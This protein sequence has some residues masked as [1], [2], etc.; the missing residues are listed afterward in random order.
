MKGSSMSISIRGI[1]VTLALAA[2]TLLA[3]NTGEITGT[4]ADASGAVIVGAAVTITNTATSQTREV[5]TNQAGNYSVP[6]LVPGTYDL[7]VETSGFKSVSRRGVEIQVGAVARIDFAMEVGEVSQRVEVSGGAPLL[8]TENAAVGTVI[9]NKRIV[10]LPL[11]GRNYLQLVALSP[12]VTT[13]GGAGGGG[14]LQG[15]QRSQSSFSIAGQRLEYNRYT[16]DGVENTDPN[17]NS[18]IIQPSVDFIQEFKVQTGVYSA[19]F[20][21]AVSQ[22]S[23]STKGGAN[24]YHGTAFEFLRN[25]AMD[26]KQWNT[27]VAKNPFRRNQYGFTLGGPIS[28]PKLFNGHDKLFFLSNFEALRDRTT[29]QLFSSVATDRMRS[30]DFTAS[31]RNIFDPLTRVFNANGLAIS[32]SP[33]AGNIIPKDRFNRVSLQLF[34]FYPRQTVPG[35]NLLNNFSRNAQSPLDQTQFNQRVDYNESSKSNWFF[36]FSNSSDAL[37]TAAVF[38]SD[39]AITPTDVEQEVLSNTRIFGANIVNEVRFGHNKFFN[40]VAHTF[41]FNRDIAAELKIPGLVSISPAAYG[42]PSVGLGQGVAGFGGADAWST[43][44]HTFQLMDNLSIIRGKHSIRFGAEIR[45]DRY[46]QLGNQKST[47]EFN[48]T[49]GATFNPASRGNTGFPFADYMIGEINNSSRAVAPANTMLRSTSIYGYVQ[50]DWKITPKLTLNLGLR[51]ENA[52]PWHDKYRG[53]MNVQ[54]FDVGVGP[55]GILSGT[56]LPIYTRPGSGDFYEGMNY[57]FADGQL[58]QSGDQFMGRSLVNSDNNNFAVRIGLAYSPTRRWT[59]RTGFGT[60]Y[61]QDT[62]NPVFDMG[63]NLGGRD[64]FVSNTEKPNQ[65]FSDPWVEERQS[66]KCTGWTGT[67]IGTPQF[68]G[69]IQQNRTPYVN[70]WLFNIQRQLTENLVLEVGYQGNEGH[71]LPRFRLYNQ[72]ILKS[73][74]TD[75]STIAQR[76]P[77]PNYGRLQEVDGIDNSNYHA[78]ALKLQQR[79]SKG[80]TYL[81]GFTWSKAIDGGSAIRTNTGDTLWPVNSYDLHDMRGPAQFDV[82]RRFV[83]SFVYELPFTMNNRFVKQVIGGWQLGGIVTAADGAPTTTPGPNGDS[84]NLNVLANFGDATG[85]S[86]TPPGGQTAQHFWNIAAFDVTNPALSYRV[87]NLARGVIRKPGSQQADLS[88]TKNFRIYERHSLQFRFDAFNALNHPSWNAPSTTATSPSTF[89]VVTTARTMRQ[90]QVAL[91]YSF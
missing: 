14:G 85:I 37:T 89:G 35:D 36:R 16:L 1:S 32:A 65:N 10:D 66:F 53:I 46:N 64:S 90:L 43:R 15:G 73:G 62:G 47:G 33:F 41:S 75:A 38:P 70:Q 31:G 76:S 17:F 13:E 91:K 74:P 34:E 52:R 4:V 40:D 68:L 57:H 26:A 72:A 12:N 27:T 20:G 79:F 24:Q 21:R 48:F 39:N 9:E 80:L 81:I 42:V 55:N 51:Y 45:R 86:I 7:R 58:I 28:I 44:N 82:P 30:G 69:N 77:W 23:A 63:R 50:D 56:K 6:Y 25:S 54:L 29:L 71:K 8:T 3:Q 88:L 59:F 87:G 18:Y 22:I 19:E 49:G 5:T 84:A 83:A 61:T 78:L 67:C 60:F 2:G 11:N